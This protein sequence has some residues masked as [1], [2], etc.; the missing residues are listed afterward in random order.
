MQIQINT[1]HNIEG[2]E[3]LAAKVS[4]AVENALKRVSAHITRVEVHL[5]D[6]NSNKKGGYNDMRCVM[7]AHLEGRPPIAVTEQ[8]TTIDEAVDG[9]ADKLT[10]LIEHTL[11][12]LHE[13]ADHRTDPPTPEQ[14]RTGPA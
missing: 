9:A 8:A 4:A 11:G 6:E 13:H 5:S 2:H 14:K 12:R 1:D 10:R 3:A 7:E